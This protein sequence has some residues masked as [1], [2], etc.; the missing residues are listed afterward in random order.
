MRYIV[1]VDNLIYF[2]E[3]SNIP[4]FSTKKHCALTKAHYVVWQL[5]C[6]R[7]N[8]W[9]HNNRMWKYD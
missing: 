4:V 7:N 8:Y 5:K 1:M 3:D 6:C 2:N 9:E